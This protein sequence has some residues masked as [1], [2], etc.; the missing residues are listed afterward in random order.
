MPARDQTR[1]VTGKIRKLDHQTRESRARPPW[2][3]GPDRELLK[4][5]GHDRLGRSQE[6]VSEGLEG[7]QCEV[8]LDL[9]DIGEQLI[10]TIEMMVEGTLREGSAG[11][12]ASMVTRL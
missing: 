7:L 10:L 3:I 9:Q 11:G 8:M 12:D 1:R 5:A 4:H 6:A 2:P